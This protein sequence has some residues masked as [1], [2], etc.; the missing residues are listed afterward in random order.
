MGIWVAL[1]DRFFFK[2]LVEWL[3]CQ[4]I[5]FVLARS[6]VTMSKTMGQSNLQSSVFFFLVGPSLFPSMCPSFSKPDDIETS[7]VYVL[8]LFPSL[9]QSCE[10]KGIISTSEL[11]SFPPLSGNHFPL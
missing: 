10:A 6:L 11:E 4:S 5:S 9:S 2:S 7:G 8:N 3:R 1:T